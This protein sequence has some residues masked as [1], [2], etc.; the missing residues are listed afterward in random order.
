M[1]FCNLACYTE[2]GFGKTNSL[3]KKDTALSAIHLVMLK[4]PLSRDQA[5][6]RLQF[7]LDFM[8]EFLWGTGRTSLCLPVINVSNRNGAEWL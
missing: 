5:A 6:G 1:T 4:N 2:A 7:F 8:S 3:E